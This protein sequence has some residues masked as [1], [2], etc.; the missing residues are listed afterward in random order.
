MWMV[1]EVPCDHL[2]CMRRLVHF[3]GVG[4]LFV[5][6]VHEMRIHRDDVEEEVVGSHHIHLHRS[7]QIEI[8]VVADHDGVMQLMHVVEDCDYS[9]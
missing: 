5:G 9:C 4:G 1:E 8:R 3:D 6:E 2:C 7:R